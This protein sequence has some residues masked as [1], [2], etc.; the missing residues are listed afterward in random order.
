MVHPENT[1]AGTTCRYPEFILLLFILYRF[2]RSEDGPTRNK[3]AVPAMSGQRPVSLLG[4]NSEE[5]DISSMASTP[6]Y[7]PKKR[8]SLSLIPFLQI[9]MIAMYNPRIPMEIKNMLQNPG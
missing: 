8:I 5:R 6:V 7:I 3:E 4:C 2:I 1:R 9:R